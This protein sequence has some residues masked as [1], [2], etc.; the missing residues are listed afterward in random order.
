MKK[1]SQILA[2]MAILVAPFAVGS[3]AFATSTCQIGYTGPNSDNMCIS[4]TNTACTIDNN[5]NVT[6]DGNNTQVAWSG[7]SS[8]NGNTGSGSATTGTA[9]NGNNQ[10]YNVSVTNGESG[11]TC[12]AVAE[13]PA[14]TVTPGVGAAGGSGQVSA[15]P[16]TTTESMPTVSVLP[17]T[18]SNESANSLIALAAIL[19]IGATASYLAVTAYR[20]WFI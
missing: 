2:I 9:T 11:K 18:S 17:N 15:T 13:V 3:S 10:K 6:I 20:R 8:S 19:G 7:N 4:K 14:T 1:I 12:V 16:T 5:N